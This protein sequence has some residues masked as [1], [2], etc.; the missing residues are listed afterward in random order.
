[1]RSKNCYILLFLHFL[2]QLCWLSSADDIVVTNRAQPTWQ[3]QT[4]EFQRGKV[5]DRSDYCK[6]YSRSY[7]LSAF[8]A[9]AGAL[10]TPG[11]FFSF[12]FF[13]FP[14]KDNQ[15]FHSFFSH[16]QKN[17]CSVNI[18]RFIRGLIFS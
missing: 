16:S 5:P 10:E 13:P 1:M 15:Y 2:K 6:R 14:S 11:W 18:S 17:L 8:S 12:P 9:R 3:S 4:F 7:C